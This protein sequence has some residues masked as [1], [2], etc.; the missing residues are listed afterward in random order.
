MHNQK[1]IKNYQKKRPSI[2]AVRALISTR[3]PDKLEWRD[4]G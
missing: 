1:T 4:K 3:K 2:L